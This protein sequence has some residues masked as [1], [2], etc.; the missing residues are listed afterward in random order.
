MQIQ[1]TQPQQLTQQ[2]NP[3]YPLTEE[4][5]T[6]LIQWLEKGI[7]DKYAICEYASIKITQY[8]E[9]SLFDWFSD[10]VKTK[11]YKVPNK[12]KELISKAIVEEEDIFTA[13][14]YAE[15]KMK[16]EFGTRT[17]ITGMDWKDLLPTNINIIINNNPQIQL[18]E[19]PNTIIDQ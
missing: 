4:Q 11:V 2:Y 8:L 5:F 18:K 1:T 17:E 14:W 3:E 7:E 10:L 16:N 19:I 12:V 15:R 6:K 13:R 9:L